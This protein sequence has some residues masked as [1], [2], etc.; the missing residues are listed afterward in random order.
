MRVRGTVLLLSVLLVGAGAAWPQGAEGK[1]DAKNAS[2]DGAKGK[3]KYD[4]ANRIA[5]SE[6]V[7]TCA[8]G[9]AKFTGGDVDGAIALFRKATELDKDA[10]LGHYLLAEALASQGKLA[11]AEAA[12]DGAERSADKLSGMRERVLHLRADL[13]ERQKKWPEAKAVW[14]RLAALEDGRDAG[15]PSTAQARVAAIG[16]VLEQA[17]QYE[18]VRARIAA[19]RDGGA[20]PP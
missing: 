4:P 12:L 8:Q 13:K 1:G 20:A 17:A 6:V 7:A 11:D 16:K 18:A 10:P 3:Q 19:E 14:E 15:G 5:P 9:A 2:Q